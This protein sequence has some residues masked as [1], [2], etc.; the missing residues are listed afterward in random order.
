MLNY[1]RDKQLLLV[2]DNVEHLLDGVGLMTEILHCAPDVKLL[3]TS[4][5][6][7][8]V[9]AEWVFEVVGLSTPDSDQAEQIEASEAVTL[10]VQRARR[11][12]VGFGLTAAE[13]PA[14]AHVCRLVEG[15]PLGD[16]KS[17][18]LNSSHI[19]KSRM[20]SSA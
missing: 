10:F 2:L 17:T 13:R 8:N 18:R 6:Q 15:M 9:Q 7:L 16:R 14:V 3:V 19:Q 4:R 1:L 5:A 12:H 20:P 11:A